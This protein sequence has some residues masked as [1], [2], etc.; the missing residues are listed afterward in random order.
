MAGGRIF[1]A[2]HIAAN[3][4]S[5]FTS[6]I[7]P[8]QNIYTQS[9]GINLSDSAKLLM[10]HCTAFQDELPPPCDFAKELR[11]RDMAFIE[12]QSNMERLRRVLLKS[13]CA[14]CPHTEQRATIVRRTSKLS[15]KL[16]CIEALLSNESLALFPDFQAKLRVLQR[17]KYLTEDDTVALKGRVACEINTADELILTETI[18]ENILQDL[19]P[20][21]IVA[22]LSAFVFQ[23]RSVDPPYLEGAL[24]EATENVSRIAQAIVAVHVESGLPVD[25]DDWISERLNFGMVEVVYEW[26]KGTSFAEIC[27]LSMVAEGTIVRCIT[28]LDETCREVRN[29]ARVIGDAV[30]FKKDGSGQRNDQEGHSLRLIA[31]RWMSNN[32][33]LCFA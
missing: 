25:Q 26:A 12:E 20:E 31:L 21:E 23:Q 15:E 24:Y 22:L 9:T 8:V 13:P 1:G 6:T 29:I 2:L 5:W 11:I 17:L 4:I 27:N 3:D 10:E 19:G 7:L 30:L 14:A 33:F 28:R 18:F 16:K 32:I